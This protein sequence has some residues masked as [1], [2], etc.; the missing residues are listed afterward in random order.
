MGWLLT[1]MAATIVLMMGLGLPD[2]SQRQDTTGTGRTGSGQVTLTVDEQDPR[3]ALPIHDRF[4]AERFNKALQVELN[5]VVFRSS[6]QDLTTW[7][8]YTEMASRFTEPVLLTLAV[9]AVRSRIK[10]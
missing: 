9:L 6:S 3:L 1:A 8:T 7:G 5:S 4:T 10:R 2:S